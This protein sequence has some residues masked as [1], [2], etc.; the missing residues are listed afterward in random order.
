MKSQHQHKKKFLI[1][2]PSIE[3]GGVEKN[4]FLIANHISKKGI[5]V[6]VI[7]ANKDKKKFFKKNINFICPKTNYFNK[8]NRFYKT[9][10]C[11]YLLFSFFLRNRDILILS[12]QA[13]IYAIFFF[14]FVQD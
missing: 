11:F 4:L 1:F 13:N 5:N 10:F 3:D 14:F 7:S 2:V 6:S 12:F 8:K 9:I